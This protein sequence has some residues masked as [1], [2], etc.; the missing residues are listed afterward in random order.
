MAGGTVCG[1]TWGDLRVYWLK[2]NYCE[3]IFKMSAQEPQLGCSISQGAQGQPALGAEPA[4]GLSLSLRPWTGL[5]CRIHPVCPL[6]PDRAQAGPVAGR[7]PSCAENSG[8]ACA[9]SVL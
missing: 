1:T 4:G 6:K 5:G 8:M 7:G 3:A 9:V 2:Q